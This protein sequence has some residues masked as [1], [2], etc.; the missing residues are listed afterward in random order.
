MSVAAPR[1][2]EGIEV[3]VIRMEW[4]AVV[5]IPCIK[6]GFLFVVG[7]RSCLVER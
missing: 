5:A 4:Y 2:D 1:S 6:D 3:S 7:K